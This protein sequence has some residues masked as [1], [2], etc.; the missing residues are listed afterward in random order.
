MARRRK[1]SPVSGWLILDK[2]QGMTSTQA[3]TKVRRLFDAAKA[4]HAGTLDPLATGVLPIALGEATKTVPFAVEGLKTYRFTVRFGTE[5]DTDD[6]EGTVVAT[7]D[8]RP[9][10]EAIEAMVP[11]F[12]GEI[13]QVPPRFSA[14]KVE[15]ARAYDLARDKEN[16]ELTPRMISIE[17]LSL[18]SC[19]NPDHCVLEA[20]CGKGTYIR[21]LARDLGRALGTCAHV[22]ALRRTRVGAFGEKDAVTLAELET[23]KESAPEADA[24]EST[25]KPVETALSEIPALALSLS[26]AARLRQ[27]QSVLLR[28]RDAPVFSGT[29]YATSRGTLIAL[30]EME[31]GEFRPKRIFNLPG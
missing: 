6:A 22:E 1:G 15:G 5:M 8:A 7:S 20:E 2:P 24:L 10:T 16:F 28:G 14:L 25:L 26:D 4:G 17:R 3:V 27:G 30:G 29:A 12:T 19:P 13:S 23:L 18:I 11:R 21:A 31:E 9:S